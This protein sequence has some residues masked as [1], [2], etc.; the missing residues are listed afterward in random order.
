MSENK[1]ITRPGRPTGAKSKAITATEL[2]KGLGPQAYRN[3]KDIINK[4]DPKTSLQVLKLIYDDLTPP[5]T[6]CKI[7]G[8]QDAVKALGQLVGLVAAGKV[9]GPQADRLE[10]LLRGYIELSEIDELKQRLEAV[11]KNEQV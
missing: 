4:G 1:D 3:V 9:N 2:A 8:P 11:E 10:R 6:L 7:S 5:V